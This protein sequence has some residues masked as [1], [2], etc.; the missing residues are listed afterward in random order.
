[1]IRLSDYKLIFVAV[2]LIGV[3]LCATPLLSLAVHLP[4]GE[5]F[6]ELYLLGPQHTL[7][8]YPFN[9]KTGTDYT[10]YLG[11]INHVGSSAYYTCYVKLRN[12]SDPLPND[13]SGTPSNLVPLH[14][15]RVLIQD[16]KSWEAPLVFSVSNVSISA[17]ESL[18]R[19]INIDGVSTAINK[20]AAYDKANSGYIYEL[21]VELWRYDPGVGMHFDSRYVHLQLNMTGSA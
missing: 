14:E 20:S 15:Y 4:A 8:N 9:I 19:N 7:E 11:V 16:G 21:V 18:V 12:L 13:T 6:S 1:V 3:L 17:G 10:L 2:G 5:R